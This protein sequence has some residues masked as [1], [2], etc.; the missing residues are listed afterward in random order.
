MVEGLGEFDPRLELLLLLCCMDVILS[1]YE[2]WVFCYAN[3]IINMN[4]SED[5]VE[6]FLNMLGLD[7]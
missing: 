5:A 6:V 3:G 4:P 1:W 7:S 2:S